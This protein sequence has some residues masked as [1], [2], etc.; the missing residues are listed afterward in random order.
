MPTEVHFEHLMAE[1]SNILEKTKDCKM[2]DET[3]EEMVSYTA[4]HEKDD[5]MLTKQDK[6]EQA[7]KKGGGCSVM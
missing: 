4:A 7:G 2:S 6:W 3:I 5:G 1:M